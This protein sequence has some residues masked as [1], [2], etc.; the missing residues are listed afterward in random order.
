MKLTLDL[1][2]KVLHKINRVYT[3]EECRKSVEKSSRKD[4]VFSNN[5]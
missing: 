5:E 4:K 3:P 2:K 1:P